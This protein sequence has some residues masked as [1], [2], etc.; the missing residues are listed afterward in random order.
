MIVFFTNLMHKFFILIHSL[1]SPT[2]FEHYYAHL[3]EDNCIS[4]AS[5]IVALFRWLFSI[6]VTRGRVLSWPVVWEDESSRNLWSER[7]SP[8]ITFG[9]RGRV[10]SSPVVWEDESSRN[11]W[12]ERTSPLVT[13]GLRGRVLSSPLVWEDESSRNLWSERTSPLVTC[14]LRGR[15]LSSPLVWEDE[16]SRHLWSQRTSP[17]VTCV[18]NSHLKTV[19]IPDTVLIELS[20]WRWV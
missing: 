2:C 14:G 20:S 19:T 16:S 1:H 10:V 13:L 11:L 15:V 18:L 4:T 12:S 17:L 6:Q 3:Q 5:G 9:L 7:T 8:L